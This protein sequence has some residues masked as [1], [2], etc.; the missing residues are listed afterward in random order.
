V[1]RIGDLKPDWFEYKRYRKS[2]TKDVIQ[3]RKE[4]GYSSKDVW[5]RESKMMLHVSFRT[6]EIYNWF[7]MKFGTVKE[8]RVHWA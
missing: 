7:L 4:S 6:E 3:W 5:I 1:D 8:V 2:I